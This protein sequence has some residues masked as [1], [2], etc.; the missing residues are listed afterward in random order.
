[1]SK[2]PKGNL[3]LSLLLFERE[4]EYQ[5]RTNY[6]NNKFVKELEVKVELLKKRIKIKKLKEILK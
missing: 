6:K 3:E 5:K 4:L 1:M 2:I